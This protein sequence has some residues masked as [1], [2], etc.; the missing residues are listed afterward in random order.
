MRGIARQQGEQCQGQEQRNHGEAEDR[1]PAKTGSQHRCQQRGEH[2]TGVASASNAHGLALV[3]GRVPLRGQWQ[4]DSKGGA[5]DA[6]EDAEQQCLLI[7]VY[8]QVPG[9]EQSDDDDHLAN[10][11]GGF[12]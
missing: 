12:R 3:L 6:E 7:T 1:V 8:A 2:R 10:Q 4:G 11:A 9:A 5:G